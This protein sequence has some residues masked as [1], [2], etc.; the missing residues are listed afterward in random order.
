MGMP[1]GQPAG[2]SPFLA[3]V[4][5]GRFLRA[6]GAVLQRFDGSGWRDVARYRTGHDASVALDHSVGEGEE[7]DTLRIVDAPPSAAARTLMIV[8]AILCLAVAAGIIWLFV[9]GG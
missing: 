5:K 3:D 6:K 9:A 8:G 4:G 2:P 1:G 7:P